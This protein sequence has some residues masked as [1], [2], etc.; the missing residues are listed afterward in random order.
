MNLFIY[1]FNEGLK[2]LYMHAI[3]LFYYHFL[4]MIRTNYAQDLTN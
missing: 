2:Q 1:I 4:S 3:Y